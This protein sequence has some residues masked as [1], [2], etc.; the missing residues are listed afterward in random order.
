V[1]NLK[2]EV[3]AAIAGNL[4]ISERY[5]AQRRIQAQMRDIKRHVKSIQRQ[6]KKLSEANRAL[7]RQATTDALT[8]IMNRRKFNEHLE[9]A[10]ER[11]FRTSVPF[12]VL[13]LDIDHFKLLNDDFGHGV[14]D[15]ALIQF[16]DILKHR[17]RKHE[18]PARYG[19]EEFAIVL[20]NSNE[21][22]AYRAAERFREAI[23]SAQWPHRQITASIGVATHKTGMTGRQLV[24][25]ADEALYHSKRNGRNQTTHIAEISGDTAEAA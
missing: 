25:L 23:N 15:N 8:G 9:M 19:G 18:E 24:Q 20:E 1:T 21:Q 11:S 2:N 12:S 5:E 16:A 7:K 13:L 17:V 14:G 22:S 3:V 10:V 4:D 6:R